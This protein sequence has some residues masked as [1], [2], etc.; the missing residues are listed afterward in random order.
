MMQN[1]GK[2]TQNK[3]TCFLDLDFKKRLGFVWQKL[4]I[5]ISKIKKW[6]K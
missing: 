6:N 1:R 2:N 5:N 4:K 3:S